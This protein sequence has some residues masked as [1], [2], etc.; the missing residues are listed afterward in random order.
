MHQMSKVEAEKMLENSS[1]FKPFF[2]EKKDG[3]KIGFICHFHV[4]NMGT[5]T[6]QLEVGYSQQSVLITCGRTNLRIFM[7][8]VDLPS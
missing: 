6:K 4:L 2:I 3:S 1:D 5:G 7:L 8:S